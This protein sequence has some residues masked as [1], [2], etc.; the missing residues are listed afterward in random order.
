M[1]FR[2]GDGPKLQGE[3]LE[4]ALGLQALPPPGTS[5]IN[6]GVPDAE[7]PTPRDESFIDPDA[8]DDAELLEF[9]EADDLERIGRALIDKLPEFEDLR[10]GWRIAFR[11]KAAGGATGGKLTLGKC[12]KAAGL[13]KH[14]GAADHVRLAR[15]TRWGVEAL[16]YH[17]L[18]HCE[19]AVNE[20]GATP[21]VRAHDFEGFRTEVA[22]YGLWQADLQ[23]A[24]PAFHIHMSDDT[25]SP[26]DDSGGRKPRRKRKS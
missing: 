15:L 11:W 21:K 26:D 7:Y 20:N 2:D 6:G 18:C 25:P 23:L 3:P 1:T 14:F 13:V 16:V 10:D 4:E 5:L 8:D 12:V 19:I 24:A 22:R 9:I 17:E